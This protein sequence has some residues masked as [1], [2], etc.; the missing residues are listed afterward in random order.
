MRDP[1]EQ[2]AY[3]SDAFAATGGKLPLE[4]DRNTAAIAASATL[5][6]A[7]VQL[8]VE[9]EI[10]KGLPIGSGLGSSAASAVAAAFAVNVLV[11]SPLRKIDLI[12]PCVEAESVVSGKHADNVAP[13]VLG[14]LVLVRSVEPLD[15]IRLP[16]PEGLCIAVVV[17]QFELSTKEARAA[18]PSHIPLSSLVR[19][20][21]NL[22]SLVAA[23]Y[24]GDLGL[25]GRAL[26]DDV[27]T[28]VR[29]KLIPGCSEVMQA[30]MA[31]GA[32]AASISGSGPSMF[33]LCHSSS[34]AQAVAKAMID[35]FASAGL[36]ACS[37]VSPLDCPGVRRL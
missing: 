23:C 27:V 16:T 1:R 3:A 32:M 4:S 17:P 10:E 31:T 18:I 5:R 29:A 26:H 34:R 14:G 36:A 13:A 35:A 8:G 24:A 15:L 19:N 7:G 37:Y 2:V 22:A 6:K 12:E 20:S 9:L 21:A 28:P 25:I 11:G 33:A 30:A